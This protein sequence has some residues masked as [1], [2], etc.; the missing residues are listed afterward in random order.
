MQQS[1][2]QTQGSYAAL[3]YLRGITVALN[4]AEGALVGMV[5]GLE[6]GGGLCQRIPAAVKCDTPIYVD[7]TQFTGSLPGLARLH[8]GGW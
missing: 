2:P 1:D 7:S 8:A 3:P 4:H 5:E 6:G